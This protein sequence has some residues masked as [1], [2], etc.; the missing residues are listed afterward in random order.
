MSD[1]THSTSS[2]SEVGRNSR[3]T[4]SRSLEVVPKRSDELVQLLARLRFAERVVRVHPDHARDTASQAGAGFRDDVASHRVADEHDIVELQV[5]HDGDHVVAE[6][7]H[8]PSLAA[9]SRLAMAGEIEGDDSVP[10]GEVR[11]LA[12]PVGPIARPAVD[13]HQRTPL[14]ASDL[15]TDGDAVVRERDLAS[16][17]P[18]PHTVTTTFA[19]GPSPMYRKASAISFSS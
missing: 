5:V 12:S 8:R 19:R 18:V 17:G 10:P 11:D 16:R 13:K 1:A 2:G 7:R 3:P 4:R 6:R 9:G 14:R 15:V